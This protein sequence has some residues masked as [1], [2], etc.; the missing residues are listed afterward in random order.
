MADLKGRFDD[1]KDKVEGT[2]KE[3]QGKVT[4][5]KGKELE[6]KAQSTFADVKTKHVMPATTLKKALKN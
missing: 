2:A 5:D 3:A 1:A 4:D 6:G